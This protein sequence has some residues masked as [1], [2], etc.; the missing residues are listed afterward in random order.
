M[1]LVKRGLAPVPLN[2]ITILV[3]ANKDID[4]GKES[5]DHS[6]PKSQKS[7]KSSAEE[8][9]E[10]IDRKIDELIKKKERLLKQRHTMN[11]KQKE[12]IEE[13]HKLD[14]IMTQ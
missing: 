6:G 11:T 14:S 13:K 1:N 7:G 2:P 8:E 12:Q 4:L 5:D 10:Q 9:K 3:K